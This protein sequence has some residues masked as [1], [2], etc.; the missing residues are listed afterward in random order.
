MLHQEVTTP[1]SW[2]CLW[3][4][5]RGSGILSGRVGVKSSGGSEIRKIRG[6]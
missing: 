4:R 6:K 2:D 1:I 3:H 5:R